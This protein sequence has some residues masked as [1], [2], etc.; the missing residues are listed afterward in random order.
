MAESSN[1][2]DGKGEVR[3]SVGREVERHTNKDRTVAPSFFHGRSIG[4]NSESALSS[5]RP[6]VIAVGHASCFLVIL[7]QPILGEAPCYICRI[8]SEV[9]ELLK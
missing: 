7:N 6:I 4:V 1:L 9:D 8:F 5:W 2:A 3:A